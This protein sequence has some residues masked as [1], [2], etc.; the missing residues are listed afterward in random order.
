MVVLTKGMGNCKNDNKNLN[1]R[2]NFRRKIKDF[3][4]QRRD[5]EMKRIS[6]G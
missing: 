1:G 2:M 5:L 3:R 4:R 6:K